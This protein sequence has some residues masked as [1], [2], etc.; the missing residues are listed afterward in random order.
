MARPWT[1][2]PPDRDDEDAL[3]ERFTQCGLPWPRAHALG[4][5]MTVVDRV[6]PGMTPWLRET[7]RLAA[8]AEREWAEPTTAVEAALRRAGTASEALAV[9]ID[10]PY[11]LGVVCEKRA[12]AR[13]ALYGLVAV[14]RQA[15]P[16][17]WATQHG[18]GW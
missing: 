6:W 14:L 16:S 7:T 3:T 8:L 15:E 2:S 11:E 4:P 1:A 9:A 13:A 17:A 18:L 5:W 10:G 12:A